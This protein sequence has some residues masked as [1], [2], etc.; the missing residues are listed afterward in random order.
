ME[1]VWGKEYE[2]CQR[3]TEP[4]PHMSLAYRGIFSVLSCDC[5]L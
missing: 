2:M 1:S 5:G 4:S 3:T